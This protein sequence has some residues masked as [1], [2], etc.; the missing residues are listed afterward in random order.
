M[1]PGEVQARQAKILGFTEPKLERAM[2]TTPR[3]W[4]VGAQA[5]WQLVSWGSGLRLGLDYHFGLGFNSFLNDQPIVNNQ[6]TFENRRAHL[7]DVFAQGRRG[8]D[9]PR[10]ELSWRGGY[11]LTQATASSRSELR[12][13]ASG[14]VRV[15]R[16]GWGALEGQ[17]SYEVGLFTPAAGTTLADSVAHSAVFAIR[18]NPLISTWEIDAWL[19]YRGQLIGL[20]PSGRTLWLHAVTLEARKSW[21]HLFIG[22]DL[23]LGTSSD[24]LGGVDAPFAAASSVLLRGSAGYRWNGYSQ[25]WARAGG[26]WGLGQ[27]R[28]DSVLIGAAAEHRFVFAGAGA[29][30]TETGLSLGVNYDV[31]ISYALA[32]VEHLVTATVT[33]GR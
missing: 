25:A 26:Q 8:F 19:G 2:L 16:A 29:G 33:F 24:R 18:V 27:A 12:H 9:D 32:Q 5:T 10:Y 30:A 28:Y 14:S 6:V 7:V 17:A 23:R 31:R 1:V 11:R 15:F 4:L 22:G 3:L 13:E 20:A 21:E